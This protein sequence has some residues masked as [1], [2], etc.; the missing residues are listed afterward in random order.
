MWWQQG[1]HFGKF[2]TELSS[3]WCVCLSLPPLTLHLCSFSQII[4]CFVYLFFIF[5]IFE[6]LSTLKWFGGKGDDCVQINSSSKILNGSNNRNV[7]Q[8]QFTNAISIKVEMAQRAETKRRRLWVAGK[9]TRRAERQMKWANEKRF[10]YILSR[11][12]SIHWFL[13]VFYFYKLLCL[14]FEFTFYLSLWYTQ[15]ETNRADFMLSWY[16][17]ALKHKS[18]E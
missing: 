8:K 7:S 2:F 12:R 4:I 5:S 6:L 9:P 16:V 10:R 1:L 11:I 17:R 3:S 18:K 14:T 15:V 13:F